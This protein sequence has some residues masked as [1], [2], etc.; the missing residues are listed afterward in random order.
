MIMSAAVLSGIVTAAD[1]T[2]GPCADHG[3]YLQHTLTG[4]NNGNQFLFYCSAD[5]GVQVIIDCTC[6]KCCYTTSTGFGSCT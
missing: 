3:E 2:G 6:T 5:F 4:Y 1:P